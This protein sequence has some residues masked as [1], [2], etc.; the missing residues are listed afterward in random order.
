MISFNPIYALHPIYS[1]VLK[2]DFYHPL[3]IFHFYLFHSILCLIF[4]S[5]RYIYIF[6]HFDDMFADPYIYI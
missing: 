1:K 6:I 4:S 2:T 5:Y 3:N